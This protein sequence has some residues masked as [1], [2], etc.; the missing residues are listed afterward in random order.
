M[1]GGRGNLETVLQGINEALLVGFEKVK[2]NAV[3]K[4]GTNEDQIIEMVDHFNG[5][6]V[7]IRFI[8]YMDVGNLNEWRLGSNFQ[9]ADSVPAQQETKTQKDKRKGKR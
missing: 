6:S 3:L 9:F 5:Q 8:E 2:I 1:T 4:R 7:I